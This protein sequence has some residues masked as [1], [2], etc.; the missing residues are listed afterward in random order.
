[1]QYLPRGQ[2][3]GELDIPSQYIPGE[4]LTQDNFVELDKL[5]PGWHMHCANPDMQTGIETSE[6]PEG[7]SV[8]LLQ[9]PKKT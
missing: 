9:N 5:N 6:Q 7:G 2:G 8:D 4:H 1:L 3:F